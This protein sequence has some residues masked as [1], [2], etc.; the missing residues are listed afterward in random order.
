LHCHKITSNTILSAI[1]E[2]KD[3]CTG[4]NRLMIVA[5]AA[6]AVAGTGDKH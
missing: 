5:R 1:D 3:I 2:I 6:I 4:A